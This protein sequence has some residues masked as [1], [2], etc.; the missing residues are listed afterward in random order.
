MRIH[1]NA[2]R[3]R[4]AAAVMLVAALTVL[5]G[6]GSN[7]TTPAAATPTPAAAATSLPQAAATAA[8]DIVVSISCD[9]AHGDLT[10]PHY[11]SGMPDFTAFWA[12]HVTGCDATRAQGDITPIEKAAYK[13]SGYDDGDVSTIYSICA[14]TDPDRS[15]QREGV[16]A[17]RRPGARASGRADPVPDAPLRRDLA[18]ER[19]PR[20]RGAQALQVRPAVR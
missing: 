5:A 14:E 19:R 20:S 4:I 18:C 15:V 7:P 16:H 11:G 12:N 2:D 3:C 17:G 9:E 10:V 1:E 13:A 8:P 6:C